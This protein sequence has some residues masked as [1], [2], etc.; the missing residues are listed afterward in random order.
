[1]QYI[2]RFLELCNQD[3]SIPSILVSEPYFESAMP[4]SARETIGILRFLTKLY[5]PQLFTSFF[6]DFFR[7][8]T[9]QVFP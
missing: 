8:Q 7:E 4:D 2:Y 3:D 9:N 6:S 5:R 1:M